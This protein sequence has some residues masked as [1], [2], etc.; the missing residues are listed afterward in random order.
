[1][2]KNKVNE[3]EVS[4][5]SD[6]GQPAPDNVSVST[7]FQKDSY[8]IFVNKKTEKLVS[9]IYLLTSLLNDTEPLKTKLRTE[10]LNLLSKSLF[11][12]NYSLSLRTKITAEF[13]A[14]ATE[15]ISLLEVSKISRLISPMNHEVIMSEFSSLLKVIEENNSPDNSSTISSSF[16]AV[17]Q[18]V[19][20]SVIPAQA[21]IQG[22]QSNSNVVN[23]KTKTPESASIKDNSEQDV[24]NK[25]SKT[26]SVKTLE[27]PNRSE[28][29]LTLMK[30]DKAMT[31]KDFATSIKDCSEKTLQ[32]ELLALV[33]KGLIKK[34]GE[35]RWSRYSLI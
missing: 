2:E 4:T 13:V 32:R 14:S 3:I 6:K 30:K 26:K 23:I 33:S 31:I 19:S 18:Q 10:G 35:R 25:T 11:S 24:F 15:I 22:F 9:A 16:F 17:D 5:I 8:C 1:M 20:P 34:E 29:I 21:G 28:K 27:K 12:P 7:F